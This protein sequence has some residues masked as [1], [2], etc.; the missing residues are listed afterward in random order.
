VQLFHLCQ[1]RRGFAEQ[2]SVSGSGTTAGAS[3]RCRHSNRLALLA[4]ALSAPVRKVVIRS[5]LMVPVVSRPIVGHGGVAPLR[6][7]PYQWQEDEV[8]PGSDRF[9]SWSCSDSSRSLRQPGSP[10]PHPQ[11]PDCHHRSRTRTPLST[12]QVC[13]ESL[14]TEP[15]TLELR[16]VMLNTALGDSERMR[17]LFKISSPF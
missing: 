10:R 13:L 16:Q 11:Q 9:P 4:P 14:A 3:L 2:S 17:N 1:G 5:W 15:D 6:L 8:A 7:S 12:I